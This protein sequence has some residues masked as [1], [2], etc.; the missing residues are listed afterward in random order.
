MYLVSKLFLIEA[1]IYRPRVI[2]GF[3]LKFNLCLGNFSTGAYMSEI[4]F[5]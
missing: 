4:E 2:H 3:F 1:D 5:N